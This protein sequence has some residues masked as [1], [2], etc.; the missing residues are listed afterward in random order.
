MHRLEYLQDFLTVVNR[1]MHDLLTMLSDRLVVLSLLVDEH[2]VYAQFL[3]S[4]DG[5][6]TTSD[7]CHPE[8]VRHG[9]SLS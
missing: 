1:R 6:R 2:N 4:G 7:D 9:S 8:L 5:G 3:G